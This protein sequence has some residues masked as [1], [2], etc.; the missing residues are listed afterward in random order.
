MENNQN[1][2]NVGSFYGSIRSFSRVLD[3][4]KPSEN[5]V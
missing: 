5:L 3:D 4:A 1:C 2:A